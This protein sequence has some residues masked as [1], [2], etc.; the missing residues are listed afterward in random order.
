MD[1]NKIHVTSIN[2]A[3]PFATYGADELMS[4]ILT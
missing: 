1:G 2:H 3:P 4:L